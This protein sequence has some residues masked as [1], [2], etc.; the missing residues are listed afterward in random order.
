MRPSRSSSPGAAGG[1]HDRRSRSGQ[2]AAERARTERPLQGL[3][4]DRQDRNPTPEGSWP[5]CQP[6]G[7]RQL[8]APTSR[9]I[10]RDARDRYNWEKKRA[11]LSEQDRAQWVLQRDAG[12]DPSQID[13]SAEFERLPASAELAARFGIVAGT[14]MLH[15]MYRT[16]G[17]DAHGAYI[18]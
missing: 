13:F 17:P 12:V 7:S 18:L 4:H 6:P 11:A 15:R 5:R 10:R 14:P 1:N 9:E 2:S 3:G 16:G 8:R